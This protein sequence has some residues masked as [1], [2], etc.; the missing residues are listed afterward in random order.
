MKSGGGGQ[1]ISQSLE[2][3]QG[4]HVFARGLKISCFPPRPLNV[5]EVTVNK[6]GD[7]DATTVTRVF[8]KIFGFAAIAKNEAR[9][10]VR[11]TRGRSN[12]KGGR[13]STD[14]LS[15]G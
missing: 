3:T 12:G 15:G 10:R 11:R 13:T 2:R 4:K 1:I 6:V 5:E 7:H 8:P 9:K 14:Y